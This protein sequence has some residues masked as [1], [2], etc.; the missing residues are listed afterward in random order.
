MKELLQFT[1][2]LIL[3]SSCDNNP[4]ESYTKGDEVWIKKKKSFI[5]PQIDEK[6]I[7]DS[8]IIRKLDFDNF[9]LLVKSKK[10]LDFELDYKKNGFIFQNPLS[11]QVLEFY[12]GNRFIFNHEILVDKVLSF[13]KDGKK[14]MINEIQIQSIQVL[15]N[16]SGNIYFLLSG[17]GGCSWCKEY[18]E[19]IDLDGK[20]LYL[21]L[22]DH[23]R[24]YQSK[25]EKFEII[26]NRIRIKLKDINNGKFSKMEL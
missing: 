7:T 5:T 11:S 12:D 14:S 15:K 2:V 16:D 19:L 17:G 25:G 26:L 10:K 23:I 8:I 6:E 24:T 22:S 9:S 4:T 18:T 3:F 1:L 21:N 20:T 13:S